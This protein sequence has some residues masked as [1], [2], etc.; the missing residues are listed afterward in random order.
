M[1][2]PLYQDAPREQAWAGVDVRRTV[3]RGVLPTT[4]TDIYETRRIVSLSDDFH[5]RRSG[6]PHAVRWVRYEG[7]GRRSPSC[8]IRRRI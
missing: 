7:T 5:P 2:A 6:A 3:R 1:I 4:L 8:F